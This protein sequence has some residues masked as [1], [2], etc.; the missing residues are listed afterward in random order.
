MAAQGE[1]LATE[2]ERLRP[3][4]QPEVPFLVQE[5]AEP[6]RLQTVARVAEEGVEVRPVVLAEQ[7]ATEERALPPYSRSR[8]M[9]CTSQ[10][11]KFGPFLRPG[12]TRFAYLAEPEGAAAADQPLQVGAL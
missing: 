6:E 4:A 10:L 8:Q 3:V 7:A 2:P 5:L 9:Q 12:G 1:D 11:T